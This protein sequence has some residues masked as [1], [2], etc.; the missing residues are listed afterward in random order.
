M[1]KI[2]LASLWLDGCSGCHMSFLDLDFEIGD[3]AEQ[4]ELVYSPLVDVKV[5]PDAVDAVLVEGAVGS[6]HA[7]ALLRHIRRHTR[8]LIAFGD[9]AVT[10]NVPGMRNPFLLADT[11]QRAYVE[12]ADEASG[13]RLAELPPLLPRVRPVHEI[14]PVDLFLPGCPPPTTAI[15]DALA[16]LLGGQP[17]HALA[18]TRF[19]A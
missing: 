18:S 9:C 11:L 7:A 1:N 6:E 3:L 8:T 4:V 12:N 13:H 10:A 14:V 16:S 2:R 17:S 15:R 19:G 5:Y